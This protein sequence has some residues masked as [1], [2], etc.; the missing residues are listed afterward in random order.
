MRVK[1]AGAVGADGWA[2]GHWVSSVKHPS[3]GAPGQIKK[4]EEMNI[5]TLSVGW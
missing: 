1:P 4:S 3:Q 2:E 5:C